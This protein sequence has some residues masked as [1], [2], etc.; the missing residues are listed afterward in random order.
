MDFSDFEKKI[1]HHFKE[2]RF[3]EVA[4][5]HRSYLNENRAPGREHNERL[6][7]LGDA[8]LELV[9]T[10]FLYAKYPEKPEGDLTSYRAALV[11]TQSISDAASKLGMN[12]YLLLS[13]GESRDQGR[14]RQII[15]ANAFEALIGALYLDSG[16]DVAQKFIADQLFHKTEEVVEKRLWQDAKSR[17]QEIAQEKHS[18]TPTYQVVSQTGPD[19]DKVFLVG[20]FIGQEKIATGEGRSKQEAE[21]DA[22]QKALAAKGW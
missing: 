18:I 10:E 13:R 6:E 4:F 19:H 12:D 1:S 9:V 14:A 3:L 17:L 21:Q 2:K 5:T 16:Y 15:L 7:F 22:A 11:N 8:V 20:A